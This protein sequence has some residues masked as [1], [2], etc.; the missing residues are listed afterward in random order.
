MNVLLLDFSTGLK[1]LETAL[2][3]AEATLRLHRTPRP[4][5]AEEQMPRVPS[6]IQ[7]S[8]LLS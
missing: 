2:G 5:R 8:L 7:P 3:V 6:F 1:T 4:R